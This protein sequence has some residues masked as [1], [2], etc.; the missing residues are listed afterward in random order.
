MY[1]KRLSRPRR[2]PTRLRQSLPDLP[3]EHR[4]SLWL[5]AHAATTPTLPVLQFT[6]PKF[7][8]RLHVSRVCRRHYPF[9]RFARNVEKPVGNMAN[10]GLVIAVS[11]KIVA[12]AGQEFKCMSRP[13]S[14][15]EFCAHC[16]NRM[17]RHRGPLGPMNARFKILR[18][19]R[20]YSKSYNTNGQRMLVLCK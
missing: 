10:S 17:V 9:A 7:T 4:Q 16:R 2:P 8:R 13:M 6:A 3:H 12:S 18:Y 15:W 1:N 14:K 20:N 19:E 5:R 11:T